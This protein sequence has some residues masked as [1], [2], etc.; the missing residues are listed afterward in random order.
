MH[1]PLAPATELP[2]SDVGYRALEHRTHAFDVLAGYRVTGV[3]LTIGSK[4]QRVLSARVTAN[5]LDVI[6]L[7]AQLGRLFAPGA[8]TLRG[9]TE[10]V[11]SDALWRE[12]LGPIRTSSA[13]L[14]V[15]MARRL[16]LSALLT[17][18]LYFLWR[19]LASL[20]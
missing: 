12:V 17:H 11:L 2:F 6:G 20:R 10:L 8:E 9:A 7:P 5:F 16:L 14:F 1:V 18:V 13:A 19:V 15:L 3:N 4:P